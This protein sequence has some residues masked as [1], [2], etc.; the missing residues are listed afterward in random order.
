MNYKPLMQHMNEALFQTKYVPNELVNFDP[1]KS[2]NANEP[3]I[4]SL[5]GTIDRVKIEGDRQ[6]YDIYDK[7]G[8]L[9]VD[10]EEAQIFQD[11]NKLLINHK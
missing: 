7:N 3:E 11:V 4:V 9:H 10:I 5:I 1:R 2:R 6:L 8:V